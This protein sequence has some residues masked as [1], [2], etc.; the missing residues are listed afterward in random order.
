MDPPKIPDALP[1]DFPS[2]HA[3]PGGESSGG[4]SPYKNLLVPLIVVPAMI[5]MVLVLVWVL[6]GSLAGSEKGPMENLERMVEGSSNERDQASQ[7]LVGQIYEH[8]QAVSQGRE[9][10]WQID[11]SFLPAIQRAWED[12]DAEDVDQRYVLAFFQRQLGDTEGLNHLIELLGL[13]EDADPDAKVRFL[14]VRALGDRRLDVR[15]SAAIALARRGDPAGAGGLV[16]LLDPDAYAAERAGAPDR[17]SG[18]ELV[19][20]SRIRAVRA[21]AALGRPEDLAVLAAA[22]EVEDDPNVLAEI[23]GA[24]RDAAGGD[25]ERSDER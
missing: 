10:E 8:L 16:E 14:T 24:L 4:Q 21:L 22:E 9:P 18:A 2:E 25:P 20:Q 13:S 19:S 7:L 5:V 6:F 1:E 11:A 3:A 12:T 23:K 17:W 15:G